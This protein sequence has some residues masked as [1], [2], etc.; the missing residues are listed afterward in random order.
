MSSK[1]GLP[2]IESFDFEPGMILAEKYEVIDQLGSGWESEVYMLRE[3]PTGIDRAAKF[4]F[5]HR[6]PRG[7][8]SRFQAKKLHKLRHCHILTQYHTQET[9][10]FE[11]QWITFLVSEF[12]EG[13]L[14]N[15][16]LQ[17]QKARRL[18]PYEGLHLLYNLAKGIESVHHLREYHGDLHAGNVFVSRK[19]VSFDV[20]LIDMYHW[21]PSRPENL[22]DDVCDLI[23]LYYDAIGGQPRY[24]KQPAYVKKI[25]CGLKRGL[26]QKRYRTAGQLREFL[27]IMAWD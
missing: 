12:V 3:L 13:E 2:R 1:S 27:E 11:D 14:L 21:G 9:I 24:A 15:Q 7:S 22:L 23:R 16:F 18:T 8:A 25:C 6:N 17:R 4:Y 19:G 20:K 26:I 10:E 5:P